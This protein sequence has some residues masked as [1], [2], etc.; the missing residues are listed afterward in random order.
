MAVA[1]TTLIVR[2]LSSQ[3]GVTVNNDIPNITTFEFMKI[4][5]VDNI[6][7]GKDI[8]IHDFYSWG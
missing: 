5:G 4:V 8:I 1:E 6:K 2:G 7:F 3:D